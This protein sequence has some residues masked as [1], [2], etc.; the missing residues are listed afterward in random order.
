MDYEKILLHEFFSNEPFA[1][2]VLP[3]V[4]TDY[5]EKVHHAKVFGIIRDF[6]EKYNAMP[7]K[8]ALLITVGEMEVSQKLH[9]SMK[10]S[11]AGI[12]KSQTEETNLDWL[13]DKTEKW[14]QE[15]ALYN[16]IIE[17]IG[18][19]D[20]SDSKKSKGAIPGILSD[21]LAVC[22]D[23][24]VGHDFLPSAE[25]RYTF[26]H[27][28]EKK[29]SFDIKLLND[30][31]GGGVCPKSLNIILAGTGAGKSHFLCHHAA[32]CLKSNLNVLYV[33]CEMSEE[34]IAER[35]DANILD[36]DMDKLREI[37]KDIYINKFNDKTKTV[38]GR[39]FIKEYP[40]ATCNVNHIRNL[41]NELKI[42]KKFVPDVIFIDY[43]SIMVSSRIRQ[44]S[45]ANTYVMGK[46]IAEEM[47][48]LA[49][50]ADLPIWTAMQF[51]R[52]GSDNS[53]PELTNISD[54]YGVAFT[55]D[56][57][58]A[59]IRT[60]QFDEMNVVAFKQLKNR[61]N[62]LATNRKFL[63]GVDRSKMKL[64]DTT[65]RLVSNSDNGG[66]DE[67]TDKSFKTNAPL[68]K[69]GKVYGKKSQDAD[70]SKWDM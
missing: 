5:F 1:R 60:E 41:L 49:I 30:I 10:E 33:T 6:I 44:D 37:P 18:I 46:A 14:C 27:T 55:A 65:K 57:S 25:D 68:H 19:M 42:K 53:D 61:Y 22:F 52:S 36:I 54:S 28:K 24:Q 13:V 20:G 12:D 67:E 38:K 56:L 63:V 39:L 23:S 64:M 50:E 9:D 35:I 16:G 26:Y 15:R 29:Y 58:L 7:T 8:E 3:Y 40:T 4:K 31:T 51:N 32:W 66:S 47:R 43:L 59:M 34:K 70:F 69:P 17:S 11:I 45:N 48:G 21:A 2:K 62:D